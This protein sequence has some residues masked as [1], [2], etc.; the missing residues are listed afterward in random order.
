V[1]ETE[2]LQQSG[3]VSLSAFRSLAIQEGCY[4]VL[5]LT[6]LGTIVYYLER[7]ISVSL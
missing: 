7:L 5:S 1:N 6:F 3:S 4:S 2:L